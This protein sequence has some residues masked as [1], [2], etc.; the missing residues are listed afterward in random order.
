M[1]TCVKCKVG[2]TKHGILCS[3]CYKGAFSFKSNLCKEDNE[4][5]ILHVNTEKYTFKPLEIM[6]ITPIKNKKKGQ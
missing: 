2:E 6:P 3:S 1:A 5:D 4:H